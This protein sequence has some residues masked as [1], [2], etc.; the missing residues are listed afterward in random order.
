MAE[1]EI[2]R[3][4]RYLLIKFFKS[5]GI[6]DADF[7]REIANGYPVLDDE[8]ILTTVAQM[9]GEKPQLVINEYEAFVSAN[10]NELINQ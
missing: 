1:G 3:E 10:I 7:L 5:K 9:R 4:M 2:L 6:T 8:I